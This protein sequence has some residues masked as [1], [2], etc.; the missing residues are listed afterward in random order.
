MGMKERVGKGN[1]KEKK[2][3]KPWGGRELGGRIVGGGATPPYPYTF[4]SSLRAEVTHWREQTGRAVTQE[5]LP[6]QGPF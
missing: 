2:K 4:Y 5:K 3:R 1:K 6:S